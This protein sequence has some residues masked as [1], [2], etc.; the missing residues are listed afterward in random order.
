M[1]KLSDVCEQ[2]GHECVATHV[3]DLVHLIEQ[4]RTS[5]A[6]RQHELRR[7]E[8]QPPLGWNGGRELSLGALRSVDHCFRTRVPS[9]AALGDAD[10]LKLALRVTTDN[11]VYLSH[12]IWG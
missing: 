11:E 1:Q 8:L 10:R 6:V 4:Q 2:L 9:K 5:F 7:R 3:V 12:V